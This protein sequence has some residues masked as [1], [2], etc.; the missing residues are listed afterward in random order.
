[1]QS[2]TDC[3]ISSRVRWRDSGLR[4]RRCARMFRKHSSRI[5]V[6]PPRAHDAG[7]GDADEQVTKR[8]QG[9]A[10]RRRRGRR[11]PSRANTRGR[12]F[13]LRRSARRAPSCAQFRRA[14]G[15]RC[16]SAAFTRRCAPT[17]RKG[18]LPS[19]RRPTRYTRDVQEVSGLL[20]GGFSVNRHDS[21]GVAVRHLAEDLEEQLE[22][23]SGNRGGDGATTL[24]VGTN[25]DHTRA[26]RRRGSEGECA[27]SHLGLLFVTCPVGSLR[28]AGALHERNIRNIR[29]NCNNQIIRQRRG[30]SRALLV[31]P[32]LCTVLRSAGEMVSTAD[33]RCGVMHRRGVS[34]SG[35]GTFAGTSFQAQVI[36]YAYV[37]ILGQRRLLWIPATDDTPLSVDG[38]T[39]GPGD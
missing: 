16:R 17:M 20:R 11:T 6:R 31:Y 21:D 36:A 27:K 37:H 39:G 1:M 22:G 2:S 14:A 12:A 15:R 4:S 23:L 33:S 9:R 25:L 30:P 5:V 13:P 3:V 10:R 24:G 32:K 8:G 38:E 7:V 35:S 26:P 18:I 29:I 28:V 19:S 34:M